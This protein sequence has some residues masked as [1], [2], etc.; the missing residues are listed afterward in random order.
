MTRNKA[1]DP[2]NRPQQA[3]SRSSADVSSFG[4]EA[5]LRM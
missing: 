5:M 4:S 2:E 1:D 3:E